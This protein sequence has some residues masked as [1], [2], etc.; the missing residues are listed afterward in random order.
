MDIK[1]CYYK[2]I[3]YKR[4]AY[5]DLKHF[6]K[7]YHAGKNILVLHNE[8]N[9]NNFDRFLINVAESKN[10]YHCEYITSFNAKMFSNIKKNSKNFSLI[11]AYGDAK[12]CN[13]AKVLALQ[14]NCEYFVCPSTFSLEFFSCYYYDLNLNNV[15]KKGSYP[16]KIYIDEETIKS[17]DLINVGNGL[18]SMIAVYDLVFTFYIEK[19]I[20][21]FNFNINDLNKILNRYEEIFIQI[22]QNN[23]DAKLVLMD[24]FI[25]I[26][27]LLKNLS[28]NQFSYYNL[29]YLMQKQNICDNCKFED[30]LVLATD[31]LFSIY[32]RAFEQK[33]I[34]QYYQPD[35]YE[36]SSI[37]EKYNFNI[38]RYKKYEFYKS[39]LSNKELFMK[40]N[41]IKIKAYLE[42]ESIVKSFRDKLKQ[43]C[44]FMPTQNTVI[45]YKK[46]FHSLNVLPHIY[47][48]NLL[49]DILAGIGVLSM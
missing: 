17:V 30:Y 42:L 5:E 14:N 45:D 12:V 37:I 26:G 19:E 25:E 49:L 20:N 47:Q 1:D 36:I 39:L 2:R 28:F 41:S 48:N 32:E 13:L 35:Y 4:N 3:V 21:G 38:E 16:T 22:S 34:K 15:F 9:N 29:A 10:A 6:I 8:N 40:L 31:I 24:N 23:D 46:L 44:M 11:L 18:K 27:Y 7:Y 33:T 43:M